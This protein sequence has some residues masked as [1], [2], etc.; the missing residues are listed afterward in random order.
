MSQ[1]SLESRPLWRGPGFRLE[2]TVLEFAVGKNIL[3]FT[4]RD[5]FTRLFSGFS[6]GFCINEEVICYKL[7]LGK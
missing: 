1:L 4:I 5:K 7:E 3:E 2:S 6:V